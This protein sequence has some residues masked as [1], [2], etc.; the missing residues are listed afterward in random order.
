MGR[1]T[2]LKRV[3]GTFVVRKAVPAELR[4][5]VGKRELLRSLKTDSLTEAE[6]AYG[7]VW[8]EFEKI[9]AGAQATLDATVATPNV[10]MDAINVILVEWKAEQ[11][12]LP[13]PAINDLTA[14]W[15][16]QRELDLYRLASKPNAGIDI[17]NLDSDIV[18]LLASRGV[19]IRPEHP[20]FSVIRELAI[21]VRRSVFERREKGYLASMA[22]KPLQ[23]APS[24][25]PV[26]PV[27]IGP[28]PSP[29][30][31]QSLFDEWVEKVVKPPE[32]ERGRLDHQIK[33]FIEFLDG[34]RPINMITKTEAGEML[35]MIARYPTRRSD[36]LHAMKFKDLITKFE[37]GVAKLETENEARVAQGKPP[38]ALPQTLTR[39]TVEGWFLSYRRMFAHAV[40]HEWLD[41]NPFD[42][43]DY[44]LTG[45]QSK[46]RRAF[47][48]EEIKTLFSHDR[49]Q[50][51]AKGADFWLP[52]L[53][54]FHGS[55][56]SELAALPLSAFKVGKCGQHYFDLQ[57]QQVKNEG[58]ERLIPV[59]PSA[60]EI[61]FLDYVAAL[62]EAGEEWLFPDLDHETRHG[63][64]H[65]FSRD[66]GRW[67]T[68]IGMDD[69]SITFHSFRHTWKRRARA[70]DVKEEIHDVLSGHSPAKV[71]RKYGEGLDVSDLARN[72]ALIEF[73]MM[74]KVKV[75]S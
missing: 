64:G 30:T 39:S 9:I 26:Q 4:G 75:G 24:G 42:G 49:F 10:D 17:P 70:S 63:P 34:D 51:E 60:V 18:R 22:S 19:S 29:W 54:L 11:D 58:S 27:V 35:G 21:W 12:R 8:R 61:G 1:F 67:M 47:T 36:Q 69:P 52:V 6:L 32:K 50:G 59:H 33:R 46:K 65:G 68:K 38:L 7:S 56:M 3:G 48:D 37:E 44:L 31:V 55:R 43:L 28:Q 25:A 74:P 72:M 14:L 53:S 15:S 45:S 16:I 66:W 20:Q 40:A 73:P 23:S 13:L 41:K 57:D 62:R 2:G 5:I 71:S